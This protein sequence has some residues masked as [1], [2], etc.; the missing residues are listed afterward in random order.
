M[1]KIF[2]V[3][4]YIEVKNK[5]HRGKCTFSRYLAG[6]ITVIVQ[7]LYLL[8]LIQ[9]YSIIREFRAKYELPSLTLYLAHT[10]GFFRWHVSFL[11]SICTLKLYMVNFMN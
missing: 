2:L 6:K 3:T 11:V 5:M 1:M 10:T 9:N 7:S 4:P 8:K